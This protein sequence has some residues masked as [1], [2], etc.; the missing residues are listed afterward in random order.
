MKLH[1]NVE[2]AYLL[3]AQKKV[4]ESQKEEID[5]EIENL[6]EKKK[7]LDGKIAVIDGQVEP[8]KEL[9]LGMMKNENVENVE[10]EDIVAQIMTR[11]GVDWK[12]ENAILKYL[13]EN[14]LIDY[15]QVKATVN[16]PA[17]KK[18]LTAEGNEKLKE[19]LKPYVGL[20]GTEYLV[21]TDKDSYKRMVEHME[22]NK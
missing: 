1:E 2:S 14:K 9:I 22:M 4:L 5:A 21:I 18:A 10:V 15:I 11:D 17:L 7:E 12:D 20:K 19:D 13:K 3:I 6:K 8:F 16:K